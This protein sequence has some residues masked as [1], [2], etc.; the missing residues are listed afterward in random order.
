MAEPFDI[1]DCLAQGIPNTSK[2]VIEVKASSLQ[3][4]AGPSAGQGVFATKDI[5]KGSYVTAYEGRVISI[6]PGDSTYCCALSN[7]NYIDGIRAPQHKMGVGSLVNR[8]SGK[9]KNGGGWWNREPNIRFQE[10]Q[11]NKLYIFSVKN[12][13]AGSELLCRYGRGYRM[14]Y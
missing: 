13:K 6:R 3:T 8:C 9:K 14:K 2:S 5:P 10:E 11:N 7:S 4:I 12:I 1:D